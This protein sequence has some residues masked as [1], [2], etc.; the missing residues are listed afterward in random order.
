MVVMDDTISVLRE[1]LA[2]A[3]TRAARAE[4]AWE[5]AKSEVAD[6][7]TALRVM[8]ELSGGSAPVSSG[9]SATVAERQRLIVELLRPNENEGKSPADLFEA[10]Q[11]LANEEISIDTFR[12][13]LWR[14]RDRD[15]RIDD[16]IWLVKG[17]NGQYWKVPG[18]FG[19]SARLEAQR[20]A[21]V[22]DARGD[23]DYLDDEDSEPP[24]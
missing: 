16:D 2:K 18:T 13:T 20:E 22:R 1:R 19:T 15:V 10:Y 3:E 24:F 11:I 6:L 12:T 23:A 5:T 9:A 14:M 21:G 8:M 7:T 17:A 4:K